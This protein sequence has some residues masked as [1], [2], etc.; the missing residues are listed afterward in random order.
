MKD[1]AESKSG[2]AALSLLKR[3]ANKRAQQAAL[4]FATAQ[5]AWPAVKWVRNQIEA[6]STYTI[7][8]NGQDDIY[9]DLHEWVLSMLPARDRR[10][11]IANTGCWIPAGKISQVG[12]PA[13]CGAVSID[14]SLVNVRYRY[15]GSKTQVVFL[16]G[17]RVEVTVTREDI[18]GGASRLPENWRVLV[19]SIVF[20]ANSETGR[21]AIMRHLDQLTE[22]KRLKPGMPPMFM[23]DRW[24]GG[25]N[26]RN[27]VPQRR[28]DSVVLR[29]GVQEFVLADLQKFLNTE[30][31]YARLG[32]PW[33]RGYLFHGVPGTGKTTLA[34]ALAQHFE[35]RI[36]YL[37]LG[38]LKN[39]TELLNLIGCVQPRSI[40]LIED[41]DVFATATKRKGEK[42]HATLSAI[43]NSLDGVW[44]PHGLVTIL[45]TNDHKALDPALMRPG[46]VDQ[47]I[48]FEALDAEQATRL[49]I[50][51]EGK[52]RPVTSQ[53]SL[54]PSDFVGQSPADLIKALSKEYQHGQS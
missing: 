38:D 24:G 15:D 34:K 40:L 1:I 35:M 19:E 30:P 21:D 23:P 31:E 47:S 27:D 53:D 54:L 48:E 39:D 7:T 3:S 8:V 2:E 9:P 18:P 46:R 12:D 32:I 51:F 4:L 45:T 36:Y 26:I 17:S 52:V 42:S 6:R 29:R 43:L 10:A 14:E 49:M 20:T 16:D 22:T 11:L 50:W 13:R 44:T 33:H 25:W 37:P 5:V 41:V 28:L